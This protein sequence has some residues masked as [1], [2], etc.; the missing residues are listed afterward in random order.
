MRQPAAIPAM[1]YM[2]QTGQIFSHDLTPPYSNNRTIQWQLP[3]KAES[4]G[5]LGLTAPS[6]PRFLTFLIPSCSVLLSIMSALKNLSSNPALFSCTR[7]LLVACSRRTLIY[8][9]TEREKP[10]GLEAR[11]FL[12][13]IA[14]PLWSQGELAQ[15]SNSAQFM[16][17]PKWGRVFAQLDCTHQHKH[18]LSQTQMALD[19]SHCMCSVALNQD[20]TA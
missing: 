17:E 20:L 2:T 4:K 12:S 13:A 1:W 14:P 3:K 16:Q 6:L 5:F 18:I 10:G 11:P 19:S 9:Q 7:V 8:T 15:L